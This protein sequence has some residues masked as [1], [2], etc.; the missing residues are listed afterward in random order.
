MLGLVYDSK[1]II[2]SIVLGIAWI[3]YLY[4]KKAYLSL[5]YPGKEH[6]SIILLE[7]DKRMKRAQSITTISFFSGTAPIDTI[8]ANCDVILR[9]NNW[10]SSRL[11]SAPNNGIVIK[12]PS[13]PSVIDITRHFSV[14]KDCKLSPELG[15][16]EIVKCV[17]DHVVKAGV[18]VVDV[19]ECLYKITVIIISDKKFA[20]MMSLS[21]MLAD[22][23]T[24]Y[25]LH[26]M[27]SGNGETITTLCAE[28]NC[29]FD[30]ESEKY[31]RSMELNT[32]VGF[33]ISFLMH[34]FLNSFKRT[35]ILIRR[36]R[37]GWI[38]E[39]K[40]KAAA[41]EGT[42]HDFALSTTG[43]AD[44]KKNVKGR[45]TSSGDS[46]EFVSTN[47]IMTS[48]YINCIGSFDFCLM[49]INCRG[50]LL[51]LTVQNAGNYALGMLYRRSDADT[52]RKIRHSLASL[53]SESD[54]LPTSLEKMTFSA[55]LM[56][57]WSSFC[58]HL[59]YKDCDLQLHLPVLRLG[60]NPLYPSVMLV[61]S[62]R[63]G[64]VAAFFVT[65]V[66]DI[67]GRLLDDITSGEGVLGAQLLHS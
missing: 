47:D 46:G 59:E 37:P 27:L 57:N 11:Y 1:T 50:R 14:I 67:A 16:T 5:P 10:L 3:L 52:P 49:A 21:H 18:S 62:P 61:F 12:Y 24:Y 44:A 64:E 25:K 20:L 4:M 53:K 51:N 60:V 66:G 31:F 54:T 30:S 36:I 56:S 29:E 38:A 26:S 39:Q 58:K 32:D 41:D 40:I 7:N 28:R 34:R 45:S 42:H 13:D 63:E 22:G 43:T 15:Y 33:I 55:G 48:W 65:V 19:N 35:C 8:K 9:K 17:Q 6:K 23:N 2:I